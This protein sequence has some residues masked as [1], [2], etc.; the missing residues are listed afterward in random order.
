[1]PGKVRGGWVAGPLL[2]AAMALGAAQYATG[3]PVA[4]AWLVI[5]PLLGSLVLR[6]LHAALLAAWTVLL[7]LGLALAGPGP[8]WPVGWVP[9]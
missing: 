1:M 9:S 8:G 3:R 4:V 6:P 5:V 2:A 7:G